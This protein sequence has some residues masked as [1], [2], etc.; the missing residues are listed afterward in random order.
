M[1]TDRGPRQSSEHDCRYTTCNFLGRDYSVSVV[2][3]HEGYGRT[4]HRITVP[5]CNVHREDLDD[6]KEQN[7]LIYETREGWL[8]IDTVPYVL[9]GEA[10]PG[11]ITEAKPPVQRELRDSQCPKR[12]P[13]LNHTQDIRYRPSGDCIHCGAQLRIS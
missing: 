7:L 5:I 13:G 1:T 8:Y 9:S 12:G 10:G 2:R 3:H 6:A 4:L 11:K